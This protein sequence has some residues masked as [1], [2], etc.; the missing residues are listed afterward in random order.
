M[1]SLPAATTTAWGLILH[2]APTVALGAQP[3]LHVGQFRQGLAVEIDH[4]PELLLARRQASQ[5]HLPA[6]FL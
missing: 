2:T 1:G 5:A 3:D 6:Q 4:A